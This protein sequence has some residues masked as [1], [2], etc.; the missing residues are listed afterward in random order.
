[1]VEI[2]FCHK[3]T[4]GGGRVKPGKA[5]NAV[6]FSRKRAFEQKFLGKKRVCEKKEF[7]R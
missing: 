5:I 6:A 2:S 1:M 7:V 4:S 3:A